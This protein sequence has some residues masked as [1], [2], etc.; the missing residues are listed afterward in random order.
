[1]AQRLL[2]SGV[3][4]RVVMLGAE[5]SRLL[6]WEMGRVWL[7]AAGSAIEKRAGN[8]FPLFYCSEFTVVDV[9]RGQATGV[10]GVADG[11]RRGG[12]EEQGQD[13]SCL[14]GGMLKEVCY[15][16]FLSADV[17]DRRVEGVATL[18]GCLLPRQQAVVFT[19][20]FFSPASHATPVAQ[21]ITRHH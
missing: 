2:A 9:A 8:G 16:S 20:F 10:D 18:G 19:G 6:R 1:M 3:W 13:Q 14:G 15:G 4:R 17:L 11:Y 5:G 21:S 12:T 7:G